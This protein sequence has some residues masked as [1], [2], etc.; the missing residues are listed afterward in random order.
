MFLPSGLR[1]GSTIIMVWPASG[2]NIIGSTNELR[3]KQVTKDRTNQEHIFDFLTNPFLGPMEGDLNKQPST[4]WLYRALAEQNQVHTM[5]A[6]AAVVFISTVLSVTS[7]AL[8]QI[9]YA[10]P[11]IVVNTFEFS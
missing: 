4:I 8:R 10:R 3:E 11:L 2:I 1:F 9:F 6:L 7:L 5:Q